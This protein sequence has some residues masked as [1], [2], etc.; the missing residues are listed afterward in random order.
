MFRFARVYINQEI[1]EIF[2]F[3]ELGKGNAKKKEQMLTK[4]V[5]T[6]TLIHSP[7]ISK[8]QFVIDL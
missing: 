2:P 5:F 6:I 1:L 3:Y 4:V 8:V 7:S